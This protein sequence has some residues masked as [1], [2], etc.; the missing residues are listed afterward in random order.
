MRCEHL[1]SY[2]GELSYEALMHRCYY[3][4]LRVYVPAGAALRAATPHP[5]P[6]EYLILGQA[7]DGQAVALPNEAGKTVFGQFFVVEYGQTLETR[8]EYELPRVA[9]TDKG[10]W[11]YVLLI[12]KQPGTDNTSVS[13]AIVLPPGAKLS[14][15]RPLPNAVDGETL[16]FELQLDTDVAVEIVY[17]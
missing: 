9:K 16:T 1:P 4:Y 5:T 11:H 8:L 6:G 12:Q 7:D 10:Q 15:A 3:D 2:H 14:T 17:E 13:L